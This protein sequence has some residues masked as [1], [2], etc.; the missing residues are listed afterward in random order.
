MILFIILLISPVHRA[1]RKRFKSRR[2]E[3]IGWHIVHETEGY[4]ERDGFL[5]CA[6]GD[7]SGVRAILH[8]DV[9]G[10]VGGAATFEPR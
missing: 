6:E 9:W 1:G 5:H 10:A 4:S 2:E 7:A 3:C 8:D